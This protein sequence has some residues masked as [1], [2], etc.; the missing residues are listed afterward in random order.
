MGPV[1]RPYNPA[2]FSHAR[3]CLPPAFASV[4]TKIGAPIG[5]GGMGEV[6]R[7]RDTRLDRVVALKVLPTALSA[8]S[9]AL[10]RFEREARAIAALN[11]PNIC[12]VHDVGEAPDPSHALHRDGALEGE[13]LRQRLEPRTPRRAA[14]VDVAIALTSALDAAHKKGIVHRDIKPSNIFLT[15]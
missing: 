7:A 14:L 11:H 13:T 10:Q 6:Y 3:S 4:R 15:T 8:N 2:Q 1:S 9:Q 5:S 12:T